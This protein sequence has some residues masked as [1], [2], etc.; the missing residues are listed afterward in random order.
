MNKKL[1]FLARKQDD[2]AFLKSIIGI[3]IRK[4]SAQKEK[5]AS[6]NV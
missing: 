1:G 6:K 3:N 2:G 4:N 5:F